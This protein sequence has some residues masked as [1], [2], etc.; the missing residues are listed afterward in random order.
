[1]FWIQCEELRIKHLTPLLVVTMPYN[2]WFLWHVDYINS[3]LQV[4]SSFSLWGCVFE[5]L[6]WE[7]YILKA[8]IAFEGHWRLQSW[9][10]DKTLPF[11]PKYLKAWE[12]KWRHWQ[13]DSWPCSSGILSYLLQVV[14]CCSTSSS[15][16]RVAMKSVVL[17]D[18]TI[19]CS[20]QEILGITGPVEIIVFASPTGYMSTSSGFLYWIGVYSINS[21]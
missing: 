10:L 21:S 16:V 18:D 11:S 2:R 1:M 20:D 6:F 7:R 15:G 5:G 13:N 8:Q 12:W 3:G 14:C 9:T 19:Q 17:N 4:T